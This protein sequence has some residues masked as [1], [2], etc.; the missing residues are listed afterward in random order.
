MQVL[1]KPEEFGLYFPQTFQEKKWT[2]FFS[3]L[4]NKIRENRL[5]QSIA[6][7]VDRLSKGNMLNWFRAALRRIASSSEDI[8]PKRNPLL[9]LDGK[10]VIPEI[11]R[12]QFEKIVQIIEGYDE[13]F[14]RRDIRF[15]FLPI[16]NQEN[17]YYEQFGMKERSE[18]LRNLISELRNKG[19]ESVDTQTAFEE[20][21][22]RD[23][24]FLFHADDSHWNP[25]GV[26]LVA[27]LTAQLIEKKE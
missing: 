17:I 13:L 14:R 20:A 1:Q 4:A 8:P 23:I 12:D 16:P 5:I 22:K 10:P 7:F 11:T 18:F 26:R 27:D 21:H 9:F 3:K 19:I 6:V 15:I 25:R 24:A 2:T